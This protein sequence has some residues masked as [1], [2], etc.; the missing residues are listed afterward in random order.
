[1]AEVIWSP[2]PATIPWFQIYAHE[3]WTQRITG[4]VASSGAG[5]SGSG[6]SAEP[7]ATITGFDASVSPNTLSKLGITTSSTGVTFSAPEGLSDAF[8]LIDLEYQIKR[9]EYHVKKW[10]D[11]PEEADEMINYEPDPSNQ[12]DWTVTVTAHL[13]DGTSATA[14]FT[15]RLL[16]NYDP[17][18]VALKEAVDARRK[19]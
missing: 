9:V 13:S 17:G 12:K 10:E 5:E 8:P 16:Q 19:S 7:P 11:L 14:N 1:M 4:T 15:L 6:G 2:D 3:P 18:K